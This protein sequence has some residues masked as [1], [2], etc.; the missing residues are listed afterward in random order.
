M[1]V[2]IF[3]WSIALMLPLAST[4]FAQ[5]ETFSAQVLRVP[6]MAPGPAAATEPDD[7]VDSGDLW[8]TDLG[9]GTRAKI[10]GQGFRSPV[11]TQAGDAVVA[12]RDESIVRIPVAGGKPQELFQLDS[13]TKLVGYAPD[14]RLLLT[15]DDNNM[16]GFLAIGEGKIRW[17]TPDEASAEDKAAVERIRGWERTYGDAKLSVERQTAGAKH[18]TDVVLAERGKEPDNVSRCEGAPCGQA[19]FE[20]AKRL[21][22]FVRGQP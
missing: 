22:V 13:I 10:S 5:R 9:A 15:A 11:F 20:P 17:L 18:W 2:R 4:V 14:G 21:V 8:V 7:E 19:A 3:R 1:P 16:V 12:I 6:G